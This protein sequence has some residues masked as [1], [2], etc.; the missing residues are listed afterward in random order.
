MIVRAWTEDKVSFK[1][2]HFDIPEHS[3][4]PKPVQKPHPPIWVAAVSDDTF[5]LAGKSGFN[6]LCSLVYGFKPDYTA[7]LLAGYRD[8]LRAHGHNPAEREI[9]ALCMVYCSDSIQQARQDFGGPVL[10]YFR[11]IANYVAPP[12]GQKPRGGV[13]SLCP[14]PLCGANGTVGR[15]SWYGRAGMRKPRVVHP[16]DRGAAKEVRFHPNTVLDTTV[17]PR[18]PKS[19]EEHGAHGE[20]CDSALQALPRRR[21]HPWLM[22]AQPPL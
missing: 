21:W 22:R 7:Q 19:S 18:Q 14:H 15:A 11:T 20:A 13:R 5:A 9:G 1:G 6:L 16:A 8:S 12:A 10:W 4:R 3:V 17:R 2:A